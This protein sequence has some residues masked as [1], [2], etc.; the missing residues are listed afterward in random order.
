MDNVVKSS[1]KEVIDFLSE[2]NSINA[3]DFIILP[4]TKESHKDPHVLLGK[5]E[6]DIYDMIEEIKHLTISDFLRCQIDSKNKFGFMYSFIKKIY[7]IS[8]FI[9]LAIVE[10]NSKKSYVISFHEAEKDEF[11]SCPYK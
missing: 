6:Y 9:K 3:D 5:L 8:V 4:R 11:E 1:K 2:I 7:N 10:E